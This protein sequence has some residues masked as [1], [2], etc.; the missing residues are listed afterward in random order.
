MLQKLLKN[1]ILT[2][3]IKNNC[4]TFPKFFQ[5]NFSNVIET[6]PLPEQLKYA[7]LK[8]FIKNLL[9]VNT[10]KSHLLTN[11]TGEIQ[12]NI[13]GMAICHSKCEKLL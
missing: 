9:K 4:G 5:G 13:G 7:L 6:I 2:K 1:D 12:I 10:E 11:T 8:R 3:A